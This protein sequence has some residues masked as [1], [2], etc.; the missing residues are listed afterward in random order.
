MSTGATTCGHVGAAESVPRTRLLERLN[1]TEQLCVVHAEGG[2][3]KTVLLSQW[4]ANYG[5]PVIWLDLRAQL[6]SRAGFWLR[7][8]TRLHA[9]GWID[10]AMLARKVIAISEAPGFIDR[11]IQR[12]F[13]NHATPRAIIID[14]LPAQSDK[15][16]AV[17]GDLVK[18]LRH[19]PD[20]RCLVACSSTSVRD[21][22]LADPPPISWVELTTD[23]LA[24][25]PGEARKILQRDAPLIEASDLDAILASDAVQRIDTLRF[26]IE[27][28]DAPELAA[29]LSLSPAI[30]ERF[31]DSGLREF[32]GLT[33][34]APVIDADLAQDLTGRS[35]AADV[36]DRFAR[37]GAGSWTQ[38]ESGHAL[39]RYRD[40][41]RQAA[42][43]DFHARHARLVSAAKRK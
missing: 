39:F 20:M 1:G 13:Q 38:H 5:E 40:G 22:L 42:S 33:A 35:D 24:L 43:A 36:L 17:V 41:V 19:H 37:E 4:A 18:L 7:M 16:P 8:L 30:M 23:D 28:H 27:H 34:L 12:M 14:G 3:G 6:S 15:W 29:S 21:A 10:D 2:S 11:M 31:T 25:S 32:A 26:A 9:D